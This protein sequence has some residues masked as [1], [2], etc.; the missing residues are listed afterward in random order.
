MNEGLFI[1]YPVQVQRIESEVTRKTS[2]WRAEHQGLGGERASEVR[3]KINIAP[4][5]EMVYYYSAVPY[6]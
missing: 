6:S 3:S 1:I 4:M 5:N 2:K